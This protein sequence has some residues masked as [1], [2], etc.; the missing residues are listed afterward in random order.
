MKKVIF[1]LAASLVSLCSVAQIGPSSTSGPLVISGGLTGGLTGVS[2]ATTATCSL[3]V[4]LSK[5][6]NVLQMGN[7]MPFAYNGTPAS[8]AYSSDPT[9]TDTLVFIDISLCGTGTDEVL[10]MAYD[11]AGNY[12]YAIL[13]SIGLSTTYNDIIN[14]DFGYWKTKM[15]TGWY[16]SKNSVDTIALFE[17]A[18]N[19]DNTLSIIDNPDPA[20]TSCTYVYRC[21]S[22]CEDIVINNFISTNTSS[23]SSLGGSGGP[24]GTSCIVNC[25]GIKFKT[26]KLDA[27]GL[28]ST[29]VSVSGSGNG[30][31]SVNWF[32]TPT[33][34]GPYTPHGTGNNCPPLAILSTPGPMTI[35]AVVTNTIGGV[36]CSDTCCQTLCFNIV[37]DSMYNTLRISQN[38]TNTA[39]ALSLV[40]FPNPTTST[41]NLSTNLLT[42]NSCSVE[43]V[44]MQGVVVYTQNFA[45]MR[46]RRTYEVNVKH[47]AA[48][49][50]IIRYTSDKGMAASRFVKE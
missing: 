5:A 34:G 15:T 42:N 7:I 17:D 9:I 35:C 48:G 50:Y 26:P 32:T 12:S 37:T 44:N 27:K 30:T 20:G 18:A 33:T 25:G 14:N 39:P 16:G 43:I 47:L 45:A 23:P 41:L 31:V 11:I 3:P 29:S 38:Q 4:A 19:I 40:A 6:F 10:F 1:T 21:A 24:F 36:S 13:K 2:T 46:G 22:P 49:Q 8:K 28:S